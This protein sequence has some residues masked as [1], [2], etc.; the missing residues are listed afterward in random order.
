[1]GL[2]PVSQSNKQKSIRQVNNLHKLRPW[3]T[4]SI[5]PHS[6][7][8]FSSVVPGHCQRN[9]HTS[10]LNLHLKHFFVILDICIPKVYNTSRRGCGNFDGPT[11][12][13]PPAQEGIIMMPPLRTRWVC[14]TAA[15]ELTETPQSVEASGNCKWE[16]VKKRK[17]KKKMQS[18]ECDMAVAQQV[19]R[20]KKTIKT[21]GFLQWNII[22]YQ[23][24]C[25]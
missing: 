1:M 19:N 10:R 3:R 9:L 13:S 15:Y 21:G 4:Q 20:L 24:T 8:N 5:N 14:L 11:F 6:H 7:L 17:I 25:L 22:N 16:T 2:R 23:I 18:A 12:E